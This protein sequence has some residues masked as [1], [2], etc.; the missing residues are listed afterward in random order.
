[1][2]KALSPAELQASVVEAPKPARK[3]RKP[4]LLGAALLAIAAA[5]WYGAEW[6]QANRFMVTTD[7]AYVGGNVTPL[8]PR[9]AGHIDQ[10]L[11]ED[12][13]HV[14]AGQP[15]IR[16]DDRPFKAALER[17]QASV[18]QKQSALDNLRAQIS[19][20]NSL[21]EQAS[22]DLESKSAAALFTAQDAKR[23]A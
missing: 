8:A 4:L 18:Q 15:V 3:R 21:I 6:W 13:Q 22:A 7:D 11:V 5:G 10:V 9:V 23:Y 19:L 12:N 16:I 2:N 17:A 20:Q 14:S 1:M